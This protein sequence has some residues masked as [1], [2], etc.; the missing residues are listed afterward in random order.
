MLVGVAF[1]LLACVGAVETEVQVETSETSALRRGISSANLGATSV[2]SP[3]FVIQ[4]SI[5]DIL[6]RVEL[7]VERTIER[8]FRNLIVREILR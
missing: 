4:P 1:I 3:T 6:D 2:P 8:V 5:D 7:T